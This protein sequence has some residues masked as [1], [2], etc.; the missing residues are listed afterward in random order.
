MNVRQGILILSIGFG[1]GAAAGC[2]GT[3]L[4]E[5]PTPYVVEV[6]ERFPL[7]P[8]PSD[9]PMTV[10]GVALGRRLFF[11]PILSRD[12]TVSCASCHDPAVAFSDP[13]R[14]SLGVGGAAGTRNAMSLANIGW[15][16]LLFW[17]GRA[18]SLEAQALLPVENP[19]E[20]GETWGNVVAKLR[21]HAAYPRLFEE[22]FGAGGVTR[23]HVV[24]AIAQFER[25]LI[26]AGSKFDRFL[27]AKADF[28]ALEQAG[29]D[30]FFSERGDCFHCHSTRLF[31]D[32]RFHNNGL[33]LVS[34]DAGLAGVTGAPV[35][36]GKFKTPSLRN[37]AYTA[38][39]M[40]DGRFQT[41]EA[42]LDHY[43]EGVQPAET[44]DP[45]MRHGTRAALTPDEK[46][47]LIAFLKTLSDPDFIRGAG[48][49]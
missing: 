37:V 17:D 14:V 4:D 31:T 47:A 45:L 35:D 46:V 23:E 20:M 3:A 21:R 9:N 26:S 19:A 44:I 7:M 41:L 8:I 36:L 1:L 18:A 28:T 11:D 43:S 29:F 6:P 10:E 22:V 48:H 30:L 40:H 12:S 34:Q 33:D 5:G 24:K 32:V 25:T 27:E 2:D 15:A 39:Y 16:P 38:P 42:V 13:R 49:P